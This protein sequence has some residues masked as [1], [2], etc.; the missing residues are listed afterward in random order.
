MWI[1]IHLV[2]QNRP[3]NTVIYS[4]LN[5][6]ESRDKT[7]KQMVDRLSDIDVINGEYYLNLSDFTQS[8]MTFY[9]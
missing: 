1:Y 8:Y 2:G 3:W 4:L 7:F 5:N 6:P 9:I